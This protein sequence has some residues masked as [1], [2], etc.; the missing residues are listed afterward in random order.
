MSAPAPE[1]T[2]RTYA[3]L[4]LAYDVF[5]E[6]L[7]EGRLPACLLTLQREKHTYGYFS[8]ARFSTVDGQVTDEIALN[9]E[10]F[11]ASPLL[12]TLQTLVHEMCHLWQAHFGKPGRGRYHN[13]EWAQK[14]ESLG[15]MPSSTGRPGGR[16]VGDRMADF[17]LPGGRFAR[18]VDHLVSQCGFTISWYDRHVAA[19]PLYETTSPEEAAELPAQALVKPAIASVQ[20]AYQ[21]SQQL[22][23]SNRVKYQCPGC[24]MKLWGKPGLRVVCGDCQVPLEGPAAPPM[25][26]E[27]AA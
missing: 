1:P 16:R 7:F 11:A 9:P 21:A 3:E 6:Q 27:R 18:A 8:K 23:R 12:E 2:E 22:D 17:M 15:L 19:A 24:R 20:A 4:R 26:A 14:M 10:Y 13:H 25:S 5:N